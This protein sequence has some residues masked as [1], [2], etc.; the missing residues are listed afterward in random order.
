MVEAAIPGPFQGGY[1]VVQGAELEEAVTAAAA[2]VGGRG[3]GEEIHGKEVL[4]GFYRFSP[5]FIT[6]IYKIK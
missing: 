1:A 6:T 5:R 2:E 3:A 4:V